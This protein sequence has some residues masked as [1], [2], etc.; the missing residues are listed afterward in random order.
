MSNIKKDRSIDKLEKELD[1][2]NLALTEKD[3]TIKEL[4]AKLTTR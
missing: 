4:S 1:K 3:K 2:L